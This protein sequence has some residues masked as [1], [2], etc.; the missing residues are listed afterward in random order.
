M[1]LFGIFEHKLSER[2][3]NCCKRNHLTESVCILSKIF[4]L[5]DNLEVNNETLKILGGYIKELPF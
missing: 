4:K 1:V 5:H 3:D 2:I